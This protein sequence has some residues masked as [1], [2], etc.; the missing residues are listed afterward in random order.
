MCASDVSS[1]R[2][3]PDVDVWSEFNCQR[4]QKGGRAAD[5]MMHK[6]ERWRIVWIGVGI[7]EEERLWFFGGDK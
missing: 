5:L 4:D 7:Y 3:F 6:L 1:L 2:D